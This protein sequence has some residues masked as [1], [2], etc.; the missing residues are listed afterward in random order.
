MEISVILPFIID[1]L[2][3]LFFLFLVFLFLV[4]EFLSYSAVQQLRSVC[5]CFSNLAGSWWSCSGCLRRLSGK[6]RH[7]IRL[8]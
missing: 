8:M 2:R 5:L 1:Q 6:T 3:Y 7:H 4:L